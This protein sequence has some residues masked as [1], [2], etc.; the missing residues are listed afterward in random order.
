MRWWLRSLTFEVTGRRSAK[1][2]FSA[3]R[4]A[5]RLALAMGS[6]LID[7]GTALDLGRLVMAFP[8]LRG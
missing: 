1:R 4:L 5:E 6:L 2:S 8:G 7:S 3:V